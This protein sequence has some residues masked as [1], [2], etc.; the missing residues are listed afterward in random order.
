MI[1]YYKKTIN[2]IK[3]ILIL[4]SAENILIFKMQNKVDQ[5]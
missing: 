5:S 2:I 1:Y 3:N 4:V